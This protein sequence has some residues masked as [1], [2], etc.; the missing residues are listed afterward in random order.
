MQLLNVAF[1][2]QGVLCIFATS[3]D[4]TEIAGRVSAFSLPQLKNV[5]SR[6]PSQYSTEIVGRFLQLT[7]ACPW[8]PR[9]PIA[10]QDSTEIVTQVAAF[11]LSQLKSACS[12]TPPTPSQDSADIVWRVAAFSLTRNSKMH[13]LGR[14]ILLASERQPSRFAG[15]EFFLKFQKSR[16]GV[17]NIIPL[18]NNLPL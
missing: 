14:A 5:C 15:T 8:T 13:I 18:Q 4:S 3:Q 9:S 11:S 16:L 1:G 12:W 7:N 10:S 17:G 6:T 2:K